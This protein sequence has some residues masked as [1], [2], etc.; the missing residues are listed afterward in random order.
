LRIDVVNIG[1]INVFLERANLYCDG[2][3]IGV[4]SLREE[5]YNKEADNIT[6]IHPYYP[7]LTP[8]N[9][10]DNIRCNFHDPKDNSKYVGLKGHDGKIEV[11]VFTTRGNSYK[12]FLTKNRT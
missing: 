1:D 2:E 4:E 12:A 7:E 3:L 11:K 6:S 5:S 8:G 9:K 10:I